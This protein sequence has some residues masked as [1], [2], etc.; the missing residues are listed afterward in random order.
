MDS[1]RD[2]RQIKQKSGVAYRDTLFRKLYRDADRAIELCNALEGSSYPPNSRVKVYNL[3]ESLALRYNDSVFA[4]E[5]QLLVFSEQQ[6]TINPNMPLRFL[7]Y[8]TDTLYSWFVEMKE[9]YKRPLFKIPTPKFY[10]LYNGGEILKNDVLRLSDA[11]KVKPGE[12][13]FH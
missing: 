7:P 5:N 8:T 12:F 6:S 3:E 4:I 10:V 11:F 9:I 1:K 13:S 2:R